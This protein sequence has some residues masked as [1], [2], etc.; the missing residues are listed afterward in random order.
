MNQEPA[1]RSRAPRRTQ[2]ERTEATRGALIAAAVR[3]LTTKGYSGTTM[4]LISTAANVTRGALVY[5]FGGLND[6]Y[7][8]VCEAAYEAYIDMMLKAIDKAGTPDDRLRTLMMTSLSHYRSE[9][10]RAFLEILF[11]ARYDKAM[12]RKMNAFMDR[13]ERQSL[14]IW[15][16]ALADSNASEQALTSVRN[17]AVSILRGIVMRP[18][19]DP[20]DSCAL[21]QLDVFVQMAAH[22]L[23]ESAAAHGAARLSA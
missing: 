11:A 21:D 13:I 23:E 15:R 20:R 5:H 14:A 8:A 19:S 2:A 1:Q 9:L 3:C 10:H 4:P 22:I 18:P 17:I 6:L 7:L 16:R 12:A